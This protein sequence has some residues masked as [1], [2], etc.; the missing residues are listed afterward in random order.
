MGALPAIA[1]AGLA[2]DIGSRIAGAA[3]AGQVD[4]YRVS[5]EAQEAFRVGTAASQQGLQASPAVG[6]EGVLEGYRQS[7]QQLMGLE[8][9]EAT[10]D[11]VEMANRIAETTARVMAPAQSAARREI[12]ESAGA[13]GPSTASGQA[14]AG[15]E[16][17]SQNYMAQLMAQLEPELQQVRFNQDLQRFREAIGLEQ[18]RQNVVSEPYQLVNAIRQGYIGNLTGAGQPAAAVPQQFGYPA[19]AA[20]GQG[21]GQTLQQA[22]ATMM[23]AN[24]LR[25]SQGGGQQFNDPFGNPYDDVPG[26]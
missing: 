10:V 4:A 14:L 21:V 6:S 13:Y 18:A 2:V 8:T 3:G 25:G 22:P 1:G 26:G 20:V 5:P 19:G 24:Y 9:P 15:A 23:L 16:A 12:R 11:P 7:A 17:Q